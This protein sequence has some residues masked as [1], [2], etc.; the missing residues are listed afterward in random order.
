[1]IQC[2]KKAGSFFQRF[3][4]SD[5]D[6]VNLFGQASADTGF[7]AG[8]QVEVHDRKFAFPAFVHV[9]EKGR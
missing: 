7:S 6:Q 3:R 5:V 8:L 9:S 1:M 4:L 2:G